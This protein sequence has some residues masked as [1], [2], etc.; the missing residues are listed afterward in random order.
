MRDGSAL[1]KFTAMVV[2]QGGEPAALENL[3]TA[4]VVRE[5]PS[6]ASG[7]IT[8]IDAETI[9]RATLALGAGRNIATDSIDHAVGC[10]EIKKVGEDVATGEPLLRI[11]AGSE[12]DWHRAEH[13]IS[14]GIEIR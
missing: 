11:H 5:L 14:D 2:A 12:S 13:M 4:A 10:D 7:V 8:K 9:G 6:P 1:A 3:P